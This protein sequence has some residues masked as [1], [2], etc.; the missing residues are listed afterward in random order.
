MAQQLGAW[1][2][3]SCL[4]PSTH[5]GWLTTACNWN[6]RGVTHFCPHWAP[7]MYTNPH[8]DT[9]ITHPHILI[10]KRAVL[11]YRAVKQ[12]V[13]VHSFSSLPASPTTNSL[14]WGD[15]FWQS[16][17]SWVSTKSLVHFSNPSVCSASSW[18]W[19]YM[20]SMQNMFTALKSLDPTCSSSCIPSPS[21]PCKTLISKHGHKVYQIFLLLFLYT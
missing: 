1:S 3:H 8:L 7:F 14:H 2:T 9:Y 11:C 18:F 5:M 19:R 12:G 6:S 4:I 17:C 21:H 13:S 15:C 20:C 10:H 16:W